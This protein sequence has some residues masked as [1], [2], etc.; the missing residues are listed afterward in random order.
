MSKKLSNKIL[1]PVVK[2]FNP[3]LE[4]EGMEKIVVVAKSHEDIKNQIQKAVSTLAEAEKVNDI[5]DDVIDFFNNYC[6][7]AGEDEDE[8]PEDDDKKEKKEEKEKK[9]KKTVARDEFGCQATSGAAKLNAMMLE[10]T[11]M[12]AMTEATGS[13]NS[14]VGSHIY[15][16][17]KKGFFVTVSGKT[18]TLT[19]DKEKAAKLAEEAEE[20]KEAKKAEKKAEK[21]AAAKEK[22]DK[23][24]DK[25]SEKDKKSKS[26]T[27]KEDKKKDKKSDK[28]A[29]KKKDKKSKK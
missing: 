24:K 21:A 1:K 19:A 6:V 18:Y 14:R 17:K 16:L 13:T 27:K 7:A 15:S 3:L 20:E 26:D 10:G 5:P 9:P 4:K 28:A 25:T 2:S 23:K 22:E 8:N 12:E 29:D 11:T